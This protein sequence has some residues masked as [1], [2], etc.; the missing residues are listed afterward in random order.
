VNRGKSQRFF[1]TLIIAL[2]TFILTAIVWQASSIIRY[3]FKCIVT[4][5]IFLCFWMR[6]ALIGVLLNILPHIVLRF[7][8]VKYGW[9]I[10]KWNV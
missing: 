5:V 10:L 8:F 2:M 9:K 1:K 7:G 4:I 3:L 6:E